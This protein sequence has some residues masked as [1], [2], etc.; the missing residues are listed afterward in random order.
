MPQHITWLKRGRGVAFGR[1][2]GNFHVVHD[3]KIDENGDYHG[4]PHIQT[5][6]VLEAIINYTEAVSTRMAAEMISQFAFE[7]HT[8]NAV[9][10]EKARCSTLQGQQCARYQ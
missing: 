3:Y 10:K 2:G 6:D 7:G 9:Q 8:R 4:N 1:D 5:T